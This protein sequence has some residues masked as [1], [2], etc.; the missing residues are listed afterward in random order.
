MDRD[1]LGVLLAIV[2]GVALI[3]FLI[4]TDADDYSA[5]EPALESEPAG[6]TTAP[7]APTY[8]SLRVTARGAGSGWSEDLAA[9]DAAGP[10]VLDPVTPQGEKAA[11]LEARSALRAYDGAPPRIPHAVRQDSASECLACHADGL[12]FR[13]LIAPA[14][15]HALY[16]SCTQCHVVVDSPVPGGALPPDPRAV[17]S[18]FDG[19]DSPES[20]PRA[21]SVAPPQ[22]PHR[23]QMRERCDSCH[24]VNGRDAIR[25]THPWR[26]SCQQC[27]AASAGVDGWAAFP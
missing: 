19:L 4:G 21:W 8:G 17:E 7:L 10:Q 12:R 23:T 27:H 3:G 20:G 1:P 16:T 5:T 15:S 6:A 9:L 11:A 14:A 24:G 25:S 26:E 13:G 22:V 2:I 18:R